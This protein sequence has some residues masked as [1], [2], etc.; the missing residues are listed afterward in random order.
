MFHKGFLN[1]IGFLFPPVFKSYMSS[2]PL[3]SI[4][5][6]SWASL[7]H[8]K[9]KWHTLHFSET[10]FQIPEKFT[11]FSEDLQRLSTS[12]SSQ[13]WNG[14]PKYSIHQ[15]KA[16]RLFFPSLHPLQLII[17]SSVYLA[18]HEPCLAF[19][20]I[21]YSIGQNSYLKKLALMD[22]LGGTAWYSSV[23]V[24]DRDSHHWQTAK[25]GQRDLSVN[26]LLFPA[27]SWTSKH[28]LL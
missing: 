10:K 15:R 19:R 28:H 20:Q 26:S 8:W 24:F 25:L 23:S 2:A 14:E 7:H 13:I 3:R 4:F 27:E 17:W 16:F 6:C 21:K 9:M 12:L 18:K 1:E 5:G 22:L 11:D